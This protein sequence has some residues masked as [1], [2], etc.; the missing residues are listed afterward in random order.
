MCVRF[1]RYASL[2]TRWLPQL[3][4]RADIISAPAVVTAKATIRALVMDADIMLFQLIGCGVINVTPNAEVVARSVIDMR[5]ECG[6][7]DEKPVPS[8]APCPKVNWCISVII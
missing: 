7:L 1:H 6:K 2:T 5:F 3:T 4:H 8:L